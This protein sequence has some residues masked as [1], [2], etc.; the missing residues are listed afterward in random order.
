MSMIIKLT[1]IDPNLIQ[2]YVKLMSMIIKL[3]SIDIKLTSIDTNFI[4]INVKLMSM[5]IKLLSIDIKFPS[6]V[7]QREALLSSLCQLLVPCAPSGEPRQK[8]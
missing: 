8:T 6:P 7:R 2:I 5:I 1:S 3:I 4:Q